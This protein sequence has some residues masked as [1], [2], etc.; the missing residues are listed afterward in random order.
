MASWPE[1][2][3]MTMKPL[4]IRISVSTPAHHVV[5]IHQQHGRLTGAA[6]WKGDD[7]GHVGSL[8]M[9]S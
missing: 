1:A 3:A 2:T 4:S 7:V 6:L 5:V 9:Q 8:R